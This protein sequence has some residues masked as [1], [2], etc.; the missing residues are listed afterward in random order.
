MFSARRFC[1]TQWNITTLR[2]S[3]YSD[4]VRIVVF[5]SKNEIGAHRIEI[6]QEPRSIGALT[7]GSSETGI[8]F[9]NWVTKRTAP[10]SSTFHH[11]AQHRPNRRTKARSS[12]SILIIITA[13]AYCPVYKRTLY[14]DRVGCSTSLVLSPTQSPLPLP[15]SPVRPQTAICPLAPLHVVAPEAFTP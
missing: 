3:K 11:S 5:A 2:P 10:P 8:P 1:S 14:Q 9:L 7:V 15:H 13:F 4:T 6:G 12:I